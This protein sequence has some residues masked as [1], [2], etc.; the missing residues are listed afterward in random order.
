M[1]TITFFNLK[2]G[3]GKT[4]SVLNLGYLLAEREK[5]KRKKILLI[6]LDMQANLTHSLLDYD[7]SRK[8]VYDLFTG[9]AGI[10]E[11]V[12]PVRDNIDLIPS[13]LSM[14]LLE[15]QLE[16]MQGKESILFYGLKNIQNEYSYALIDCSPSYSTVTTNAIFVSDRIFIPVQTEYYAVDG[17]HLL[18]ETLS[19]INR[20]YRINKKIDC[21]FAAMHDKRNNV[22]KQQYNHL[23]EAFPK[24]F[25]NSTIRK[26]V[27]LVEAPIRKKTIF[28]YRNASPGARDYRALFKE[29][30]ERG[31]L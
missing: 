25:M 2:G 9:K 29:M 3:C 15:P 17:V 7:R 24:R 16:H 5:K 11:V 12:Y 4:T 27:A 18:E 14:S 13:S 30:E 22:G 28:E 8:C 1:K 31:V 23:K 26:N 20:N 10:N 21:I 6:D 19:Y